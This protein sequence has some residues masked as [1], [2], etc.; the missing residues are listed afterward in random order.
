MSSDCA[1]I[2]DVSGGDKM[3]RFLSRRPSL[4]LLAAPILLLAA[5]TVVGLMTDWID[6]N[7]S[8]NCGVDKSSL[9]SAKFNSQ[10]GSVRQRDEAA[11]SGAMAHWRQDSDQAYARSMNESS[12]SSSRPDVCRS[13]T[14]S[15]ADIDTMDV[16]PTLNFQP[17]YMRRRDFWDSSLEKRYNEYKKD[18]TRPALKVVVLPHSHVDPGWL[19]TFENYYAQTTHSILD[20]LVAKLTQH[21]NMTFIWTEIAYFALWWES[22]LPAKKRQIQKLVEEGRLEFTSGTWVMV[23]EATPH[24]YSMLD[25]MIEG[26]QWLKSRLGV[27]PK[28]AWTVDPFGH[29]PVAPYLLHAAGLQ[30]TVVQRIHYGWKRWMADRQVSDF[31]WKLPW[32]SAG[33]DS[34]LCH[35]FPYDIYTTKHSCGPNPKTCLGYDF[36]NVRGEYNEFTMNSAPITRTNIQTKAEVLLEQYAKTGSLTR[37][38]IVLALVGDDFRYDHDIEWDQQ[39]TNYQNLFNYINARKDVYQTEIGFGTLT[40]YFEAVRGRVDNFPTVKGDFFPYADIFSEGRPAYWT[41]YFTSRPYYKMLARELEDRLRGAEILYTVALNRA[42]QNALRFPTARR[43]MDHKYGALVQARRWLALFQHHDAITG[44]SKTAV[45]QDYGQKLF[46]ALKDAANIASSSASILMSA[47]DDEWKRFRLLPSLRRPTYDKLAQKTTLDL[48]G[49]DQMEKTVVLYN[50][51]AHHRDE[52]VRLKTSWPY[53]RVLDP[54]GHKVRHQL[55]P[56]WTLQHHQRLEHAPETFQLVFIASLAPLSLTAFRIQ[57]MHTPTDSN[58]IKTL[59]YSTF[60]NTTLN[61]PFKSQRLEQLVDIQVENRK[62]KLL[63][64]GQSG[65]LKSIRSKVTDRV[66]PCAMQFAAYPSSMFHSG[67]YL[68]MPDANAIDPQI[69]V[70]KGFNGKP[71]IFIISGPVMSEVS[72]VYSQLLV[73]STIIFH[74]K[75]EDLIWMETTLDMGPAP[76]FREHEFFIRFKT[77]LQNVDPVN[78]TAEF[79]TDQNGFAF[80]RR[81]RHSALGVEANYYPI[82]SA[83]FI[84]DETQR[85]NVLVN[86]AKGF[87]SLEKGWMEF[88]L[89][90]RTIHDDGRG[91][92]EGMTDNLPIITPFVLMLEDRKGTGDEVK[93]LSLPATFASSRL[94][95]PA[96]AFIVDAD[97]AEQADFIARTRVLFLNQP[98]PCNIHMVGLRTLSEPGLAEAELPSNSALLTLHNRAIDCS[99]TNDLALC[100]AVDP[101]DRVFYPGTSFIGLELDKVERTSLT[102]LQTTGPVDFDSAR[103]PLM[104]LGSF[105]LTF[106]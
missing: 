5:F 2:V 8:K 18:K 73:H 68:F 26:H 47:D 69:D 78:G 23:D 45:M 29:G 32:E 12:F 65:F 53:V 76:N 103:L 57:R 106:V 43:V 41:G 99:I 7:T 33:Q 21:K 13:V 88:M 95:Y 24:L 44:T 66:T 20:N 14:A 25:Q 15:R 83:A 39:Y 86:S 80:A 74:K 36:R 46:Q 60:D 81:V 90:R 37:H 70:L 6:W 94:M 17:E 82:T 3:R 67:A 87:T 84:Q 79:F 85:L 34:I 52:M 42:R 104:E 30:N 102:G 91:M 49:T 51:E 11:S 58:N 61:G 93:K 101:E 72:V 75:L 10:R 28:S 22:A 54:E 16:Y 98:L 4:R 59:V 38:N 64:D 89:D 55:N 92:G 50:S 105:N 63:F 35:N 19:K 56:V 96:A 40:D 1:T 48:A 71:Q 27:S 100:G 62:I 97:E 31:Y 77:G 9:S